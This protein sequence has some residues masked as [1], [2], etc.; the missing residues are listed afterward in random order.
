MGAPMT[1][2]ELAAFNARFGLNQPMGAPAP[3]VSPVPFAPPTATPMETLKPTVAETAA[4]PQSA[5]LQLPAGIG[6]ASASAPSMFTPA[7]GTTL[8]LSP[9]E[10][11]GPKPK[12]PPGPPPLPGGPSA[13]SGPMQ[14][15]YPPVRTIP[16]GYQPA[17]RVTE[18]QHTIPSEAKFDQ[19]AGL[20]QQQDAAN[21]R[22]DAE[23][24]GARKEMAVL[25]ALAG[26]QSD[27]EAAQASAQARRGAAMQAAQDRYDVA[28]KQAAE[29]ADVDPGRF[30][31]NRGAGP[32]MMAII[33]VALGATAAALT[34]GQ[35][36]AASLVENAIDRD[37]QAQRDNIAKAQGNVGAA[38][39]VLAEMRAQFGDE[40]Q[41]ELA[42]KDAML[43]TTATKLQAIAAETKREDARARTLDLLGQIQEK[44]GLLRQSW[45][46]TEEGNVRVSERWVPAQTVGGPPKAGPVDS[47]LFVPTG[48]NGEGYVAKTEKEAEQGRALQQA[49]QNLTPILQRLKE[50]RA[51]TNPAERGV[52]K[53]GVWS[54]EDMDRIESLQNQADLQIKNLE[55]AGAMDKGMQELAGPIRGKWTTIQ[56][57]PEAAA[58]EFMQAIDRKVESH[59]RAQG[60]QGARQVIAQDA[61][62]NMVATPLGQGTFAAPRA[63]M[64]AGFKPVGGPALGPNYQ[65]PQKGQPAYDADAVQQRLD[66][67]HKAGKGR[68]R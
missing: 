46:A 38:K 1:Q 3:I 50:L 51:K 68:G 55:Q 5:G 60:G 11:F 22:G 12:A 26:Q 10:P 18:G 6:A 42:A 25:D 31:A 24:Q 39:G 23:Q 67:R 43:A 41:A 30:W 27:F 48:A 63:N 62:G 21:V 17:S 29:Q 32:Q 52:N 28:V 64:P 33:G 34:G 4:M 14:L 53:Y 19:T 9:L 7:P 61:Q 45:A 35:N 2:E 8:D 15:S 56:G 44:R 58:D 37:L 40:R 13:T 65:T 47:K 20:T 57:N 16:A 59:E 49:R 36:T 54:T 66:A